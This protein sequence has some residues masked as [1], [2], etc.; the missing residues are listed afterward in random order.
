VECRIGSP[1][2]RLSTM[3]GIRVGPAVTTARS[4]NDFLDVLPI[5]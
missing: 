2:K 3:I 5:E 1:H 4:S